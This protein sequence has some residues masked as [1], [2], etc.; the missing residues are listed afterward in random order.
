MN[1][2]TI[3]D[4]IPLLVIDI[5]EHAYYLDYITN[6]K[7]YANNIFNYIN[8]EVVSKRFENGV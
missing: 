3:W 2:Q 6:K 5:W 4:F 8:W 1:N 7:D